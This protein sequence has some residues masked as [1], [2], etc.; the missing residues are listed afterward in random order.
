MSNNTK[1]KIIKKNNKIELNDTNKN[2]NNNISKE[3]EL[4]NPYISM[5]L[6]TI[7]EL[8]HRQLNNEL[9]N[10]LKMN[11]INKVEGKCNKYGYVIKV[12]KI[13]DYSSN[14]ILAEDLTSTCKYIVKYQ[15]YICKL[16]K[17][18]TIVA[19]ISKIIEN[20]T[21][22]IANSGPINIIFKI[23]LSD[24]NMIN[25]N[26]DK[27]TNNII[28]NKTNEYLK[29]G[30]YVKINIINIKFYIEDPLI[31]SMGKLYDMASD[32]EI[33]DYFDNNLINNKIKIDINNNNDNNIIEY[34]DDMIENNNQ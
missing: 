14:F 23:D 26:I 22:G 17:N 16:I 8:E 12:Q 1:K 10:N 7:I 28:I 6:T 30:N 29:M 18:T 27:K 11:L 34:N 15:A 21:F 13:L 4:V 25:F 31:I 24:I 3:Y 5:E 19:Q 20:G 2:L 32:I 9:Y 33:R